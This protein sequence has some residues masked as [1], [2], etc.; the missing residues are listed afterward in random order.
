ML[1]VSRDAISAHKKFTEKYQLPFPLLSD[2]E[3]TVCNLYGVMKQKLMYGKPSRGIERSTFL[4]DG[5][6]VIRQV[7]RN[8]KVDGHAEAVLT[9]LRE[10]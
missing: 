8:V 2:T 10:I 1:G 9:A 3:E 5:A 4:I 6:G 7:W